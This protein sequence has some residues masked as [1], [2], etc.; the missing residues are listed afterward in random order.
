MNST[1]IT[2]PRNSVADIKNRNTA[3]KNFQRRFIPMLTMLVICSTVLGGSLLGGTSEASATIS[4]QHSGVNTIK[5]GGKVPHFTTSSALYTQGELFDGSNP[6]AVCYTC[7]AADITGSAPPSESLDGGAGVDPLTGDFSAS[8]TLFGGAGQTDSLGLSLNYDA[9]LAQSELSLGTSALNPFGVGWNSNFGSSVTPQTTG[10]GASSSVTV[11]QTNGSQV[12]FNQSG[13]SGTSTTCPTGDYSTTNKYTWS[14][15]SHQWCALASVQGQLDDIGTSQIAY[16]EN[17]GQYEEAFSWNGSLAYQGPSPTIA[18]DESFIYYDVAPGSQSTFTTNSEQKCPTTAY[19]CTIVNSGD[20]QRDIVEAQNSSG[21]VVEVIDPS[22]VTYAL[23]YDTHNNLTTV[24]AYANQTSPSTWHYL[25]DTAQAPPNSSDLVEI[26]DPDSGVGSSPSFSSGAAHSTSLVYTNAGG[27][28]GM[29]SSITDGTGATTAYSY[30]DQCQT[31]QCIGPSLSLPQ[32]T[33]ITYPAQ[34]PCPSCTAISP[35]EFENYVSGV[36]SSTKLGST[37]NSHNSETWSYN[38]T[39]GYGAGTSTE[40]ISYPDSLSGSPLTA[41]ATL[42]A[43]GNVVQTE[44]ALGDYA[45]SDYNDVGANDLPELMWSYPGNATFPGTAPSGSE[46]YTYNSYGQTVTGTDPLGNVTNYGY[47]ASGGELCYVAPPT[48]S[49]S[50]SPPTCSGTGT[51]G[52]ST[53]APVGSTAFTYDGYGDVTAQSKDYSDTA[54]GADPQATTASYDVM[55]NLLWSISPSG[56]SGAQSSSNSYATVATY[57]PSNLA[58]TVTPPGEGAT[59]NTYDAALNLVESRAPAETTT[60]V[61]DADNRVCYQVATGSSPTGLTCSSTNQ[62]GS[63]AFTYVPGSTNVA[64]STD[65]NALTT[66][67][68]YEDLAYPNSPTEVVDPGA[69]AIQ[70]AAYNDFGN[71]CVSGDASLTSQ[72]GTSGQCGTVTGDTTTVVNALGNETSITDPSGNTTTNAFT[73]TSYPTSMTSSTNALSEVTSY[74]YDADGRVVKATNPDT[75]SVATSYDADGRVCTQ[76]DNGTS[77]GCGAGSGVSGVVSY[78]YNGASDR[79]SMVSY[80]PASA[81]TTYAYATGQLTSTTDSNAKTVSYVYNY[82]GQMACETYPVDVTTGCGTFAS[83]GTASSTNTL[84]KDTYDSAG[85][86]STVADWLG[87]TTSYTY[88]NTWTPD[89]PTKITYPTSSGVTA[90][91]G[92][93]NDSGVTSLSAGTTGSTPISDSWTLDGD[94]RTS[95]TTVN[96]SASSAAGYNANNQITAATN[97]ATSTSN[98][99]YTV[100]ANGEITKDA[101]P[102]GTA[103]SYGY[104]AGDELCTATFGSSATSCGTNPSTGTSFA[105][106]ANGQGSS[107]TPYTS[108]TAGTATT[109]AWNPYGELCNVGSSAT[110]CGSMPAVGT[111]YTYNGDGLRTSTTTN[112]IPATAN[113]ISAVGSLQ[114]VEGTGNSTLSVSPVTV[115][116]A[117]VFA[118]KVKDASVTITGLS[119]GGATWQKLTNAGSNPDIELWLGTIATTGSST[120]TVTYSGSVASDAIELDAQEYTNGTGSTT[121][122]SQD[123]VGSSNNTTSSTTVTFPTLTPS[124]SHELYVGFARIPNTGVAGSTSGFTYDVTSPNANLYIYNPN[125]SSAVSPTG[126]ES[127]AGTSIAVGALITANS[128][129]AVGSLQQVEGTGNSTLSVS[130]VTVGDAFVFAAKVKD[131]SVTISSV[132][133]GGATWQKLT[134][135]GSNPDIELWL[136][137]ITTT[138]SSTI[139]VTYSGSVASDAIE[140]DAQEYTNGTGSSTTWSQDVV[141]SSNN[142]T[143]STTVAF[144]TLTPSA[145]HELY[146]GFARIPNT[147]VAGST[148]GFTYD[149]TSP[150]ANLYIYNPNVSSAVSPTGVESPAGTSIAVGALITAS[151]LTTTDSTWDVVSGGSI[152]L[153]INDATTRSGVT[154]NNSYIYGDLLL[155]GTAP[156]EQI[157]TTSSGST[158]VFIVANQTGVQGVFSSLGATLELALYSLYGRQTI[159]SGANVT[160]FGY[161]GSYTDSTGLIYLINRYF[162]PATDQFV[163]IDPMVLQTDQPYAVVGDDPLNA[164]DPWGLYASSGTGE[165]AFVTKTTAKTSTKTTTK[166]TIV[167]TSG[168]K[169]VSNT[170]YT[171]LTATVTIPLGLGFSALVTASATVTAP[172]GQ[173]N[174]SLDAG[175]DGSVGVTANGV[176]GSPTASLGSGAVT[177][178]GGVSPVTS[179]QNVGG[180]KVTTSINV[181]ISYQP[182]GTPGPT[183]SEIG[184]GIVAAGA[185]AYSYSGA[186]F[187]YP[188]VKAIVRSCLGGNPYCPADD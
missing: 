42:D 30:A 78:A 28:S 170:S 149:V 69:V 48:I 129:S 106:T 64:T 17:G 84:V 9:Q 54:T 82:T 150:N 43:A 57:T 161:Q 24:E 16:F 184:D 174:P 33:T 60:T 29:V 102:T 89:S 12:T 131:A 135:A 186:K 19:E 113:S 50:G 116:D 133:G 3:L 6:S 183:F 109:Y 115:G 126:V 35:V 151:A 176:P 11:N 167:V 90:N 114:Q 185:A 163:S 145:T 20:A 5:A 142:T 22:G 182:S 1:T 168:S 111:S 123:V 155:G 70:Y 26:Y 81:T 65:A 121:T 172:S 120:I 32:Q 8:N 95:V 171:L 76:S 173:T 188:I 40:T 122:W 117:F 36:E 100:A 88:A 99:T 147:G 79:T 31:G 125:V 87:N 152:P 104:N 124:A 146:V 144:P 41:T 169:V 92:F 132:S 93:D 72:Q 134:N 53:T 165:S 179:T 51:A 14:S 101:P 127:P 112:V 15:S 153:N 180:D 10:V 85:R 162:D 175:S 138:G 136:G 58:L 140:L 77:Y 55:G 7:Q 63:H 2:T 130:P 4:T 103:T 38:W 107:A 160:P 110:S 83:P 49:I 118:A 157:T 23:T 98:D 177:L 66:S 97:L 139:T 61:F 187:I 46:I 56:Q 156:V 96:G 13:S 71:V 45:T 128:I 141:G 86:L 18:A 52:P 37:S 181:S 80:S 166:T 73:N 91:Y 108:G 159:V 178:S 67:Y 39:F 59:T 158:A 44:N 154:T 75:T 137:T 143:S 105:Y 164:T 68:Y 34:V 119:G 62:G 27:D 94:Q 74:N 21:H 47:Y 25:Y 148:S